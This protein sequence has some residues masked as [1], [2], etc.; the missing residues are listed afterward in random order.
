WDGPC[1]AVAMVAFYVFTEIEV[2]TTPEIEENQIP[3]ILNV[4]SISNAELVI[5]H[6]LNDECQFVFAWKVHFYREGDKVAYI[7]AL[8]G[9]IIKE[10]NNGAYFTAP[11]EI[12]GSVTLDDFTANGITTLQNSTG[13]VKGYNLGISSD[14]YSITDADF[15]LSQIPSTANSQ[16]SANDAP[17]ALYQSFHIA[18]LAKNWLSNI[19]MNLNSINIGVPTCSPSQFARDVTPINSQDAYVIVANNSPNSWAT[20]DIIGHELGHSVLLANS[21]WNSGEGMVLHEAIADMFGVYIEYKYQGVIDWQMGDDIGLNARDLSNPQYKCY[22]EIV[23]LTRIFYSYEKGDPLR[24]WFYLIT[25]GSSTYQIPA[26]GIEKSIEIIAD[27]INS[28]TINSG[29]INYTYQSVMTATFDVVLQNFGR[30]SS[31]FI[32]IA[33]AWEAICL[34]TGY[35]NWNGEVPVCNYTISGPSVV[36]EEDDF[37]NFCIQGGLPN[38]YYQWTIIGGKSTQYTSLL[39]MQGNIQQGGTCLNL[40]DFPKYN[41]YP[42]IITIKVYSPIIGSNF[43]VMKTVQLN[44]CNGDDPNCDEY[45]SSV[46]APITQPEAESMRYELQPNMEDIHF[47]KVFNS[48]GI[49]INSDSYLN[50]NENELPANQLFFIVNLGKNGEI[51]KTKKYFRIGN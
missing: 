29:T 11:T 9:D 14:C 39:G 30:C 37:A 31:E 21:I 40:T 51:I 36:C 6:N 25:E 49:L 22:D 28:G 24:Y 2:E 43:T 47:I 34:N 38:A 27:A 35:A 10:V 4:P 20:F 17:L 44:D 7:D 3:N 46:A 45:Y 42:Q 8:N 13:T 32:A 48:A 26:L 18:S 12:Y 23:D 16:W 41:Y 50:F 1:D 5:S 19:N 33:R 15:N